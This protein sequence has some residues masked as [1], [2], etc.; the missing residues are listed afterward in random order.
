MSAA[1]EAGY[2]QNNIPG[3]LNNRCSEIDD[4]ERQFEFYQDIALKL[5]KKIGLLLPGEDIE[6]YNRLQNLRHP[7]GFIL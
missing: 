5:G 1:M 7:E 4:F 6:L 2:V 3:A